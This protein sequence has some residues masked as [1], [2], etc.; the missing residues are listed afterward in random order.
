MEKWFIIEPP[1]FQVLC[2]H[3]MRSNSRMMCPLRCGK[4]IVEYNPDIVSQMSD[5]ALEEALRAEALRIILKHPYERRP[6]GC[7][8]EA[9]SLA[10]NLVI[11]D[12]YTHPHFRIETPLSMGLRTG[13]NY[14]WYASRVEQQLE[15]KA[16]MGDEGAFTK[17]NNNSWSRFSNQS[18]GSHNSIYVMGV[19][20]QE[21]KDKNEGSRNH[22]DNSSNTW[23]VAED[24]LDPS[25]TLS[26]S[27]SGK[28][29]T[30]EIG[31]KLSNKS[32]IDQYRDLS[33]LWD[34]DELMVET[35]NEV[36]LSTRIWGSMSA[37]LI[38]HLKGTLKAKINWRLVLS[39]FRASII[40]SRRHLTR[41]KPNRRTGFQNMGST[42]KFDSRILVA[43]DVSGSIST[44]EL[45]RFY[46]VINSAFRYG[47]E[48]VDVIQF[49]WGIK[50]VQQLKKVIKS[51]CV[52]GRGGTSFQEP[53]DYAHEHNYDGLVMM[54]DGCAPPPTLPRNFRTRILWVCPNNECNR[55]N[56]G[57]M[58]QCGRVCV[59]NIQ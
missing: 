34:E 38:E 37:G 59:M 33:E 36:I 42:R 5:D 27:Q 12:N 45:R 51:T 50:V 55:I 30:S 40:T 6:E 13:M 15:M 41:M 44:N 43:V 10:S 24:T 21:G 46:G 8:P 22:K 20:K 48:S 57:W 56:G 3:E 4:K 17:H 26:E 18:S 39:G 11:G 52:V 16:Q 19:T 14:E 29:D 1:L 7:S 54:T 49:D 2:I 32:K 28:E 58:R 31:D 25:E 35:I 47:F 23:R 53:I 9:I